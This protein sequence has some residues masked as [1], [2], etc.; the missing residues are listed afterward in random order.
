MHLSACETA[1]GDH[2]LADEA[3]RLAGVVSLVGYRDVVA[4][5]W[6]VQDGSAAWVA[7]AFYSAWLAQLPVGVALHRAVEALRVGYPADPLRWAPYLHT[8]GS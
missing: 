8:S 3:L 4:T 6:T 5:G 1:S 7:G 2:L